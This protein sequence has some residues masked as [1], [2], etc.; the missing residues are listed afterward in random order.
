MSLPCTVNQ[1]GVR[2]V[3]EF[4]LSESETAALR[5]SAGVIRDIKRPDRRKR[6]SRS[7][8]LS[9]ATTSETRCSWSPSDIGRPDI[10]RRITPRGGGVRGRPDGRL[11]NDLLT[12]AR[13][14]ETVGETAMVDLA[15]LAGQA[16]IDVDTGEATL[17]KIGTATLKLTRHG[18]ARCLVKNRTRV[19][20]SAV[21]APITVSVGT[22]DTGLMSPTTA[23]ESHR[24]AR[25]R[26]RAR[27]H[28]ERRGD[29]VRSGN[30]R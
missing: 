23:S 5:E 10:G 11:I 14:G 16:W 1:S 13:Q 2:D 21:G 4:D 30:R 29:R 24:R 6:S 12:L 9:L 20:A 28:H 17:E 26:V 8:P 7:S 27:L 19:R 18:S 3:H 22:T 15:A 25:R